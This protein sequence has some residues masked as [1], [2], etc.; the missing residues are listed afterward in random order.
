MPGINDINLIPIE[1]IEDQMN[2]HRIRKWSVL[3]ICQIICFC[4]LGISFYGY[5]NKMEDR[6]ATLRHHNSEVKQAGIKLVSTYTCI[7]DILQKKEDLL[8][9]MKPLC[10][11]PVLVNLAQ[12][13]NPKTRLVHLQIEREKV[14]G[15]G[16][17]EVYYDLKLGGISQSYQSLSTFLLHLQ[18]D[19]SFQEIRLIKSDMNQKGTSIM[20]QKRT[21]KEGM[22][23]RISENEKSFICFE[24]S[25]IYRETG[26]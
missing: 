21:D 8:H 3:I 23:S 24:I 10:F 22:S 11:S 17:K 18:K 4:L 25:L 20:D 12:D 5:L 9:L 16:E 15:L 14:N 1:I 7:K 6:A 19:E 26:I 2:R 13:M